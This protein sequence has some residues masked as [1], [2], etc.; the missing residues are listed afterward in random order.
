M[1]PLKNLQVDESEDLD[2][3]QK[4]LMQKYFG[5]PQK[6]TNSSFKPTQNEQNPNNI[7]SNVVTFG[8]SITDPKKWKLIAILTIA[9]AILSNPVTRKFFGKISYIEGNKTLNFGAITTLF[10]IATTIIILV[11]Y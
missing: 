9:F 11:F 3:N 5:A 7:S 1:D 4:E 8:T 6:I 10:F 2:P